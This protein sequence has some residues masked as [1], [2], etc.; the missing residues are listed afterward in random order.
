MCVC[1]VQV[2]HLCDIKCLPQSFFTLFFWVSHWTWS[3]M[4]WVG[5][6]VIKSVGSAYPC[7]L[8]LPWALSLPRHLYTQTHAQRHTYACTHMQIH[9]HSNT[10]TNTCAWTCTWHACAHVHTHTQPQQPVMWVAEIQVQVLMLEHQ[11][12]YPR[13]AVSLA[14]LPSPSLLSPLLFSSLAESCSVAMDGLEFAALFCLGLSGAST[15]HHWEYLF[16]CT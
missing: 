4:F 5:W 16:L 7:L 1:C 15:V 12:L 10:D 13:A 14:P 3:L 6:S 11:A 9:S 8:S 2:H